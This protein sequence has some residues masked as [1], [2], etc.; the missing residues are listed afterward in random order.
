MERYTCSVSL[1]GE[2][3]VGESDDG[4]RKAIFVYGECIKV[5][6]YPHRTWFDQTEPNNNYVP[7]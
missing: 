3:P 2:R 5:H 1:C 6:Y 4:S 7:A